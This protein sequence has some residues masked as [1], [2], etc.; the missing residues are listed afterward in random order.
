M[1]GPGIYFA[2]NYGATDFKRN[3]S[4]E[5]GAIFCAV[6]DMARVC[7]IY[8]KNDDHNYSKHFNSKYLRHG[9][10]VE[11]DE[12]VVYS[13][14]QVLEYTIIV[15]QRA[16]DSFRARNRREYCNCIWKRNLFF[17]FYQN[18]IEI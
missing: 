2:T 7:E 18:S 17:I 12:F 6:L 16:I 5:G 4:T 9:A 14:S 13:E 11:Y 10:G 8:D 3:Q 1:L 15:E